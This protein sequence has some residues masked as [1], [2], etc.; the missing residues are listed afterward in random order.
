MEET[1]VK[2]LHYSASLTR[3]AS[4]KRPISFFVENCLN[5]SKDELSTIS[6]EVYN[7]LIYMFA[8]FGECEKIMQLVKIE[9]SHNFSFRS[10]VRFLYLL[11]NYSEKID[12]CK[13]FSILESY[14]LAKLFF[15]DKE[16]CQITE[17]KNI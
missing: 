14:P 16:K 4:E 9:K 7:S 12:L 10:N 6:M 11:Y 2:M 15:E 8:S 5:F 1:K 13:D 3:D 17:V